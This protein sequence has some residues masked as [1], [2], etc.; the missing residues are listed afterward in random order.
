[1]GMGHWPKS[2]GRLNEVPT[3]VAPPVIDFAFASPF[4]M[5]S[6]DKKDMRSKY[7]LIVK[8]LSFPNK[9]YKTI[10]PV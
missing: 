4:V 2:C 10:F 6:V 1:M 8:Y 9:T 7:E 3:I 5:H